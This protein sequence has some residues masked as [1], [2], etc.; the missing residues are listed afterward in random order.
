M[1]FQPFIVPHPKIA[2]ERTGGKADH[3]I[4]D[5][6]RAFLSGLLPLLLNILT[7]I[8]LNSWKKKYPLTAACRPLFL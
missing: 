8:R 6:P 4:F 3:A 1:I 7:G 5:D 2:F